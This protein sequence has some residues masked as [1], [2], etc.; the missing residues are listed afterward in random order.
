MKGF[1]RTSLWLALAAVCASS[2]Y[3]ENRASAK[4]PLAPSD[5]IYVAGNQDLVFP[6]MN[7]INFYLAQGTDLTFSTAA[8]TGGYGIQ[9][10]FFGSARLN[11][12]PSANAPCLYA[13]NGGDNTIGSISLPGLQF[14]DVFKGSDTDDGSGDGIGLVSNSNY[15]YAS[16]STSG[17]IATFTLQP[18]CGLSLLGDVSATGLQGGTPAGIAVNGSI[19]V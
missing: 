8:T 12:I 9:G 10:G 15:L 6:F 1:E 7:N 19:L 2:C 11:T 17:T 4:R 5:A 13:S 16:Y 18:G 14:V 3:G